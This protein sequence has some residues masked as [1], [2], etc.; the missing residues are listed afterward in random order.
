MKNILLKLANGEN[1]FDC[2]WKGEPNICEILMINIQTK[3]AY[4]RFEKPI[5]MIIK[6]YEPLPFANSPDEVHLVDKETNSYEEW[7]SLPDN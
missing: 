1:K 3:K 4:V 5:K 6:V 7:I 2:N